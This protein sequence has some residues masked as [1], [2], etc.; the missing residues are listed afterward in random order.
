MTCAICAALAISE[1]YTHRYFR[2]LQCELRKSFPRNSVAS[3]RALMNAESAQ[4]D[5]RAHAFDSQTKSSQPVAEVGPGVALAAR[6]E[7]TT[8]SFSQSK[9]IGVRV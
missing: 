5:A 2:D 7:S 1:L 3:D 9:A 4:E 8:T 6:N